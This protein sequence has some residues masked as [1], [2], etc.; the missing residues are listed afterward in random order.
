MVWNFSL[1]W[2]TMSTFGKFNSQAGA[3]A[4]CQTLTVLLIMISS[5]FIWI[6]LFSPDSPAFF[7]VLMTC[8]LSGSCLLILQFYSLRSVTNCYV[9]FALLLHHL[10]SKIHVSVNLRFLITFSWLA[11]ADWKLLKPPSASELAVVKIGCFLNFVV[12]TVTGISETQDEWS[13]STWS[14]YIPIF[15][16]ATRLTQVLTAAL[17]QHSH[18]A[19]VNFLLLEHMIPIW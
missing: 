5:F 2:Q 17:F 8:F 10:L 7:Q 11:L 19:F 18:G 13:V 12:L 1:K 3:F 15:Q 4:A 6:F 16:R 9:G 14:S